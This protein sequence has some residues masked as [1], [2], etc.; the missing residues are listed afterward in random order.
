VTL[1]DALAYVEGLDILGMRFG[2]ERMH[3]ILAELHHP[4]LAA[5]AIHVVGTNG[6]TS[7]TRLIAELLAAEG[8]E[9]GAYVSPHVSSWAE[10]II[11]RG[12][13]IDDGAFAQAI[14]DVRD[15]V[16]RLGYDRGDDMVTQFEVVTAAGFVALA[17]A[18][19]D[20]FVIEAG[21]GGRYDATNVLDGGRVSVLTNIALE[22]TELLGNTVALIA[23]EKLAIVPDDSDKLVVGALS[24]DAATA[25]AE[26]MQ[27][28]KLRGW[29]FGEHLDLVRGANGDAVRVVNTTYSRL[30]IG[31]GGVYQ[32]ENG[33]LAIAAAQR[34]LGRALDLA[35]VREVCAQFRVPGRYEVFAGHPTVIIDGAH[36]PAGM[37]AL[38]QSLQ[39]LR[40]AHTIVVTSILNDKDARSMLAVLVGRCARIVATRSTH[41]R[42]IDPIEIAR[43]AHEL[44]IAAE[45]AS[46]PAAALARARACAGNDGTVLVCGSLYLL[47]DV[48]PRIDRDPDGRDADEAGT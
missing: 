21:L 15:A 22:H 27:D 26:L 36:N 25:V 46:D 43:T 24:G 35:S 31:A 44:G 29:R 30:H 4:H 41:R 5:P 6:K 8:L 10:R 2:L 28:R 13:P 33:A 39:D 3:A 19:V 45:V 16:M 11:V 7:T 34:F 18:G 32:H 14:S 48:R 12:A 38:A 17:A 20:V 47:A 23:A 42:A 1:D 9:T 37:A 40:P